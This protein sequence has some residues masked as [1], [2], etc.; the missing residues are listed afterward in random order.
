[1]DELHQAAPEPVATEA[2][3]RRE[4]SLWIWTWVGAGIFL[5]A[6]VWWMVLSLTQGPN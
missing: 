3:R 6:F 5:A 2:A 1:M 4:R